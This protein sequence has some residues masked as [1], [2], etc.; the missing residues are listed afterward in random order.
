MADGSNSCA[1]YVS[2][3]LTLLGRMSGV[4]GTLASTVRDLTESGWVQVAV[5]DIQPGDV[6]V[7]EPKE[8]EGVMF[9]HIGFYIGDDRAVST[10]W[11]KKE[12]VEHDLRQDGRAIEQ[13]FRQSNW[14]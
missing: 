11:T 7:W 5:A 9:R 13:V 2:A 12:V 4:H 10:S 14:D 8:F 3:V 1:F 6:V